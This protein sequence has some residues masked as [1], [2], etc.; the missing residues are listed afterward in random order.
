LK[1]QGC[2]FLDADGGVKVAK[3]SM[4]ILKGERTTN[5]YKDDWER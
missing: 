3:D 4:I 5:L 2:K 1:A